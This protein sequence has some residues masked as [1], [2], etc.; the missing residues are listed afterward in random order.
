MVSSLCCPPFGSCPS[1]FRRTS[2]SNSSALP[3]I[4]VS[5]LFNSCRNTS[6]NASDAASSSEEGEWEREGL[7]GVT[8]V[9]RSALAEVFY[10]A[11]PLQLQSSIV[12]VTSLSLLSSFALFMA[13]FHANVACVRRQIV[14]WFSGAKTISAEKSR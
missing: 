5:G 2:A 8:R 6:P 13:I 14:N 9:W 10:V 3:R 4:P 7:D 1:F 11:V 12:V